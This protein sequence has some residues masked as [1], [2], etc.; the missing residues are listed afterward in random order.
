MR[1]VQQNTANAKPSDESAKLVKANQE[2]AGVL[3]GAL[4]STVKALA[5]HTNSLGNPQGDK[6]ALAKI[7]SAVTE[8]QEKRREVMD[9]FS[10]FNSNKENGPQTPKL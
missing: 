9:V 8:A 4:S 7:E 1:L 2:M 6:K 5:D 3:Q 10:S